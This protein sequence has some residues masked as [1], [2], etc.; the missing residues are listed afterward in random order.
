MKLL[1]TCMAGVLA[2]S[3]APTL[4][5]AWG[6]EGHQ[7]VGAIADRLLE[8]TR[9]G[10]MV[11]QTL[12]GQNLATVAVWADCV[13]GTTSADGEHFTYQA[14]LGRFPE[15]APFETPEQRER[16]LAFVK[17][18]WAQCGVVNGNERCH[19]QYH[20]T[21][22]AVQRQRYDSHFAGTN[23]HDVVHAIAAMIGVLQGQPAPRPFQ[24][25][26]QRE[27]LTLLSHYIGD[28][29]Q[30]L[31]VES[32]YLDEHGGLY[33]P[34]AH[35]YQKSTDTAGGNLVYVGRKKLH[36]MWDGIPGR[37]GTQGESFDETVQRARLVGVSP[38]TLQSWPTQ[39]ANEVILSGQQA[40]ANLKFGP[41]AYEPPPSSTTPTALQA[42]STRAALEFTPSEKAEK[43][44]TST[45]W[46]AFGVDD[47]YVRKADELK[48]AEIALAGAR[49]AQV[50]QAIWPETP[51][52]ATT[53]RTIPLRLIV[54]NDFHGNLEPGNLSLPFADPLLA[55]PSERVPVGGMAA[56]SGM[57]K[58]LRVGMPYSLTL[59]SGDLFGASPLVSTLYRHETTVMQMNQLELDASVVGNHE[60]DAGLDELLR[61]KKG[62]CAATVPE[63]LATSCALKPYEGM[64][65]ELLGANVR[66]DGE[67]KAVFDPVMVKRVEG[68]PVAFI[69][70]VTKETPSMVL[71]SGVKGL[72]FDDE[73]EVLNRTAEQLK[74]HGIKAIV[75]MVH[76]GGEVGTQVHPVDWNDTRCDQ[77]RGRVFDIARQVSP[78]VDVLLTA[79]THQGYRCLVDGRL[80]I[81]GTSF[82]RGLSVVDLALD[83]S[84]GDIDRAHTTSVNLPVVNDRTTA[85]QRA[86]LAR[87]LPPAFSPIVRQSRPDEA[88]AK[89]VAGYA[90]QIAPKAN[91]EVARIGAVFDKGPGTGDHAMGRLIADAQLAAAR[92]A[93]PAEQVQM[94]FMNDGGVRADLR[95]ASGQPPCVVT[96]GQLFAAQ[97]FS[98]DLVVM[99]LTGAQ[100]KAV[101]EQQ[102]KP[103]MASPYFLQPSAGVS[104]EW[105]EQAPI[106]QRVSAVSVNGKPLDLKAS[107]RVV[108]NT[109]LSQGGDGF[110]V[111]LKGDNRHSAGND[112][113]ALLA[114]LKPGL[115]DP[116]KAALP[117]AASRARVMP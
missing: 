76:E 4:A 3:L 74:R 46:D 56:L 34:D 41:H 103:G 30:P 42:K 113:D 86:Q 66:K 59:S 8:G 49:L 31:H 26:D 18:N 106:G 107:Y 43:A 96:F 78:D 88:V 1:R 21:D 58:L 99:S 69:G 115:D 57:V 109:F 72:K 6:P 22:V 48:Q 50:L 105:H 116:S 62:G 87:L 38:G 73:V 17:A 82:G 112:L 67:T 91:R 77:A 92:T 14:D 52:A 98:N 10:Q 32:V 93:L 60:F 85:L 27:A 7:A 13:K 79:H 15:C 9:A 89:Q 36:S 83:P 37:L 5:W 64:Q 68:I 95:C 54:F 53:P 25:A 12:A 108:V 102:Q 55:T 81:Q 39:W 20:Y 101:L 19:N 51:Q 90:Q 24:I 100:I 33:D 29:H 35:G 40:F 23:D 71:P 61:L 75:A 44:P 2:L 45:Q 47:D 28:L 80:V 11:K 84:T 110:D 94:A 16:I 70:V 114:Y 65:F 104:Y 117:V 63:A 111:F 97:P